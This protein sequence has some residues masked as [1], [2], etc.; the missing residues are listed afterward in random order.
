MKSKVAGVFLKSTHPENWLVAGFEG[1][2]STIWNGVH[3]LT[4]AKEI[5]QWTLE[6][7]SCDSRELARVKGAGAGAGLCTAQ[8]SSCSACLTRGALCEL[9][10]KTEWLSSTLRN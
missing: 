7:D 6:G 10:K 5:L 3:F 9:E 2:P 4:L 1:H 8:G